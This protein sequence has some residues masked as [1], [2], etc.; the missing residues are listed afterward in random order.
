MS[1]EPVNEDLAGLVA[2]AINVTDCSDLR[3]YVQWNFIQLIRDI[4][5]I[6]DEITA[7]EFMALNVILARIKNRKLAKSAPGG[8]VPL[9]GVLRGLDRRGIPP[10]LGGRPV[11]H[12]VAEEPGPQ[13]VEECVAGDSVE[14]LDDGDG[15]G[16]VVSG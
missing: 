1:A 9:D 11:L 5:P 13:F 4:H 7:S 6:N 16:D 14:G 12:V 8:V 2:E 10:V 15:P 3:H